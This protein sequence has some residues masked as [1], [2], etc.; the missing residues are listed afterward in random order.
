MGAHVTSAGGGNNRFLVTVQNETSKRKNSVPLLTA[1]LLILSFSAVVLSVA[2]EDAWDAAARVGTFEL[3]GQA[4]MN[5]C[6]AV[7]QA[8]TD[9][10]SKNRQGRK[11]SIKCVG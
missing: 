1:V 11:Q 9:T 3:A 10:T 8:N 5:I 7:T 6:G 4:N 2:A